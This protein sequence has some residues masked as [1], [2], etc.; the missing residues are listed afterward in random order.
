LAT[1]QDKQGQQQQQQQQQQQEWQLLAYLL[2][3]ENC[4]SCL[5]NLFPGSICIPAGAAAS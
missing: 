4:D 5:Q 2:L 1:N 3:L